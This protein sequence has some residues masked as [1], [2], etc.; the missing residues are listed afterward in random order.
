MGSVL[1]D[2]EL[3][4][5]V[6]ETDQV[7]KVVVVVAYWHSVKPYYLVASSDAQLAVTQLA[8]VLVPHGK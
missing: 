3:Y 4:F 5:C 2:G 8:N 6:V 1:K 7:D